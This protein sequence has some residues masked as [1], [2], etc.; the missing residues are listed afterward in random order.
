M[1]YA[2]DEY[3]N[4][5]S[6]ERENALFFLCSRVCVEPK[7]A[8]RSLV[9]VTASEPDASTGIELLYTRGIPPNYTNPY[10]FNAHQVYHKS[11]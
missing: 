5:G 10:F 8:P 9:L 2:Q 11:I 7:P 6:L 4:I 1:T 3:E